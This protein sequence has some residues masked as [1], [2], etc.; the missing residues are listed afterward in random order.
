MH[1]FPREKKTTDTVF[2]WKKDHFVS[3]ISE[4]WVIEI[5]VWSIFCF[6]LIF[7]SLEI[8]TPSTDKDKKEIKKKREKK[9]HK[10]GETSKESDPEHRMDFWQ[11]KYVVIWKPPIA[12]KLWIKRQ[13]CFI[14]PWEMKLQQVAQRKSS[15]NGKYGSASGGS[16]DH[17]KKNHQNSDVWTLGYQAI[18]ILALLRTADHGIVFM[19]WHIWCFV[20]PLLH[21]HASYSRLIWYW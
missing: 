2:R 4:K 18:S 15:Q 10:N 1:T 12:Q 19:F 17:W 20:V 7:F 5:E 3:L 9:L 6:S 16:S 21:H 13:K 14:C 8:E 11:I